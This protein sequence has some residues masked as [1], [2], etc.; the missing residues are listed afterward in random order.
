MFRLRVELL[1]FFLVDF[2][3]FNFSEAFAG[4][5]QVRQDNAIHVT[6]CTISC[7]NCD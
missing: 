5:W 2:K 1:D 3:C 7:V 6:K 4:V